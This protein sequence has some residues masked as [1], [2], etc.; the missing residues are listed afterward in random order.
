MV[1]STDPVINILGSYFDQ[2]HVSTSVSWAGNTFCAMYGF[3]R[4]HTLAVPSPKKIKV[5]DTLAVPLPKNNKKSQ[6]SYGGDMHE[7]VIFVR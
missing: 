5:T 4:S 3:L 7:R 1:Q 2:S 6:T